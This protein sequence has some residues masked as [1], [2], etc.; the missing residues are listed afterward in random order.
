MKDWAFTAVIFQEVE[1]RE[2]WSCTWVDLGKWLDEKAP[3]NVEPRTRPFSDNLARRLSWHCWL[4]KS[5]WTIHSKSL[6]T[7]N[8]DGASA[9]STFDL[10]VFDDHK[11]LSISLPSL[12]IS[13]GPRAT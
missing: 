4:C 2:V 13:R 8:Y 11:R 5:S 12:D 6:N 3:H 7:E 1:C 10:T 9:T